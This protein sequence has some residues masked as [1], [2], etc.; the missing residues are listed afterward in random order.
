MTDDEWVYTEEP[1]TSGY[2][3]GKT[4]DDMIERAGRALCEW[5]NDREHERKKDEPGYRVVVLKY[6]D[7]RSEFDSQARAAL[8]AALHEEPRR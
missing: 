5:E 3:L 4:T 7:W 8:D 1:V 6:E 2:F